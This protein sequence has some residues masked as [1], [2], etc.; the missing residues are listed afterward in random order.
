MN[1]IPRKARK[2]KPWLLSKPSSQYF[3]ILSEKSSTKFQSMLLFIS[4]IIMEHRYTT[5]RNQKPKNHG[6]CQNLVGNKWNPFREVLAKISKYFSIY[7]KNLNG[8]MV[9]P[10]DESERRK[11]MVVVKTLLAIIEILSE[12]S[13]PKFQSIFLFISKIIMST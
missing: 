5:P 6:C 7:F 3:E 11:T 8:N 9:H 1:A 10:T 4:K 12:K 13:S 2:E